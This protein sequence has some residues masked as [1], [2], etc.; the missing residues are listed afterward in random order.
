MAGDDFSVGG[1]NAAAIR[2]GAD[3]ATGTGQDSAFRA[4]WAQAGGTAANT[5]QQQTAQGG[6]T[7]AGTQQHCSVVDGPAYS[8]S[9]SIQA[10]YSGPKKTAYF[11]F[12]AKFGNDAQ[13]GQKPGCCE[14]HQFFRWD[15]RYA[16]S[17][18]G[19]PATGVPSNAPANTDIED[20]NRA[21]GWR[22]GHRN[23]QFSAPGPG[24]L[25]TTNGVQD[26]SNG[27]EYSGRDTPQQPP[28]IR[29]SWYFH[30][31]VV[32]TCNGNATV[33]RSPDLEV[34]W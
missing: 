9:G 8:A 30:T 20:R 18:N 2:N 7:A 25:Y 4:A 10:T 26:N 16:A 28:Y 29:G 15:E 23:D 14:V 6:S 31:E 17:H 12:G 1:V 13:M 27:S 34:K 33:K 11:E 19:P 22:Y 5:Q 3:D 32:D 21:S 24:N